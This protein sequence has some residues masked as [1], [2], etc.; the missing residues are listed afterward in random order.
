MLAHLLFDFSDQWKGVPIRH[1]APACEDRKMAMA[2][3][4]P[5]ATVDWSI[6]T[7]AIVI[8]VVEEPVGDA[9]YAG[10]DALDTLDSNDAVS[11]DE[12]QPQEVFAECLSKLVLVTSEPEF[13]EPDPR[14]RRRSRG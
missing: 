12:G 9:V 6:I 10:I 14:R 1:M 13:S 3:A 2:E 7:I 5:V 11:P 4:A 8:C